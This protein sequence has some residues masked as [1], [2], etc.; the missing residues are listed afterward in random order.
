MGDTSISENYQRSMQNRRS[1]VG[2]GN[3][4]F[5]KYGEDSPN[6]G[7][8]RTEEQ[9][10]NLRAGLKAKWDTNHARKDVLRQ[11]MTENNPMKGKIPA[12]AKKIKYNGVVYNSL[13]E[14]C[15]VTGKTGN[16][17]KKNGEVINVCA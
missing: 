4:N 7:S 6:F 2:E 13:S 3:P 12:N 15:R 10:E 14:A 1:Y 11:R 9:K 5:G 16:F 8:T 17:L